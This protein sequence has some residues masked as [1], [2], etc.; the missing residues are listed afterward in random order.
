MNEC[1]ISNAG[2]RRSKMIPDLI[3]ILAMIAPFA[4]KSIWAYYYWISIVAAYLIYL[5]MR[6]R[7]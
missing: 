5:A 3:F 4:F 7:V 6:W 2:F 1:S